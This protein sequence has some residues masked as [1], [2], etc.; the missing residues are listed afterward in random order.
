LPRPHPSQLY[1]AALEGLLLFAA[2]HAF[3]RALRAQADQFSVLARFYLR[4]ALARSI[5]EQFREA[6]SPARFLWGGLTMGRYC[7]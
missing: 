4:L 2:A 3:M 6:G 7:R 5:C 1:E